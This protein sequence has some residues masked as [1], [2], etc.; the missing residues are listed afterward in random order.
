MQRRA[1][2]AV[3][4]GGVIL[5]TLQVTAQPRLAEEAAPAA[6]AIEV[7]AAPSRRFLRLDANSDGAITRDEAAKSASLLNHF[8]EIDLDRDGRI[9]PTE[10][11]EAWRARLEARRR[12]LQRQ[13]AQ[14]GAPAPAVPMSAPAPAAD[15]EAPSADKP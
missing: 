3:L 10:L 12:A 9:S 11:R 14:G 5:V 8:D 7:P 15:A 6:R 1:V 2:L 13:Q 4:A